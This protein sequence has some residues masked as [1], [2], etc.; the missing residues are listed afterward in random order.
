[1]R[2]KYDNTTYL[3]TR[4]AQI[5]CQGKNPNHVTC[6]H[7]YA[8]TR[9]PAPCYCL[10]NVIKSAVKDIS[11]VSGQNELNGPRTSAASYS[12]ACPLSEPTRETIPEKGRCPRPHCDGV[13]VHVPALSCAP[14]R[15]R[16]SDAFL[17]PNLD[18]QVAPAQRRVVSP[19]SRR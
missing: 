10:V 14:L 9:R 2:V 8:S 6:V 16:S 13:N 11:L 17:P 7:I 12:A 4:N 1:M 18:L 19:V 15:L 3:K 5:T